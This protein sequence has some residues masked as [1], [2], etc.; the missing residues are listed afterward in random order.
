MSHHIPY[1]QIF[2]HPEDFKI[3]YRLYS[4]EEGG[5][6]QL[7]HQ[8]LRLNF[9]YESANHEMKGLF[10]IWPEFEDGRGHLIKEGPVLDQ[11]V[12]RMWI[13]SATTRPYHRARIQVG[14]VGYFMEGG[15]RIGVCEVI[16]VVGLPDN[17]AE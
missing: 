17:P 13:V 5:R 4:Q 15:I 9:W 7:P 3:K 8:G 11:G 16:E 12:A 2:G 6:Y 14:T 10:M 1:Q